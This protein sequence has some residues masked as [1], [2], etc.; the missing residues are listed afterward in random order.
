MAGE[1]RFSYAPGPDQRALDYLAAKGL[2][3]GWRTSSVW[4]QEHAFGFTLAGIWRLDILD[5]TQKML[6]EALERGETLEAFKARYRSRLEALGFAG[7]QMVTEFAEGPRE[8]NLSATWRIRTIYDTNIRNAYAAAEWQAIQDTKA[9]F[10]ALEYA[11]VDDENTR[12]SHERWFGVVRLVD[13][14]FWAVFYPPNDWGCRCYPIQVSVQE[15]ASG[16][17]KLTTDAEMAAR[18]WDP[19]PSTWQLWTDRWTGRTARVPAGVSPAFAYNAGMARREALGDLLG[20][21]LERLDPDMARAAAADLINLPQFRD[22]VEDAVAI[23]VA[24][25]AAAKAALQRLQKSGATRAEALAE[26]N[27]ARAGLEFGRESWPTGVMPGDLVTLDAAAGRLV[28]VNPSAIGHSASVHPTVAQDWR[29]LQPMLEGGE[30][31]QGDDGILSIFGAF[32]RGEDE[33]TWALVLKPVDGAWRVRTLFPSSPRR[34]QA[35]TRSARLVRRGAGVL[36][37][38]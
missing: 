36:N 32:R 14:P 17:V 10:P 1:D 4:R 38:G 7:P 31:W 22:L 15:L 16:A 34:R 18:G 3:R 35:M 12:E 2:K 9:D 30:V 33:R 37:E 24:R 19:D 23:G 21:K 26:A 11:G 5:A 13:D 8:V 28:V 29:R 20:R 25:E 27:R 6:V